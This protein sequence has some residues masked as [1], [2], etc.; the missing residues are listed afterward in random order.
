MQGAKLGNQYDIPNT[1]RFEDEPGGLVRAVISTPTADA[2]S[3]R[4]FL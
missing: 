1:L 3:G 4:S 2:G